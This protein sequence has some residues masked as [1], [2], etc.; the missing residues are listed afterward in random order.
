M[1][2][3][4]RIYMDL[5]GNTIDTFLFF[6]FA[7]NTLSHKIKNEYKFT[8]LCV[9][10]VYSL[11]PDAPYSTFISL[12]VN[13]VFLL[14]SA[15]PDWKRSLSVLIKYTVYS[16]ISMFL[17]LFLHSLAFNDYTTLF[18]SDIYEQYKLI[19]VLFLSY[20]AYVLYTNYRQNRR[21][22]SQYYLYFSIIIGAVCLLV[23]YSTLYICRREPSS[24]MLPLLFT[25][26][27]ILIL[28]CISL[29]DRFLE[30]IAENANY[31]IQVKINRLQENYALQIEENLKNLR[32]L[33]HDI[34]NHLIIIDGYASQKR[35]DKIHEYIQKIG[36]HFNDT[37]P[38]QTP[39]TSLSAILSEKMTLARQQKIACE[40]TCSLP[41]LKIDDFTMITILGNLLDNA[42][43][44]ASK[45]TDGWIKAA[46]L[47]ESS[48]L[49]ITVDNSHAEEIQE[50]DGT[51]I[52][53]K[54]GRSEAHGIGIKNVRRAVNNLNGQMEISYTENVFHVNIILP[55]Y[56]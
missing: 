22:R 45:C 53:T 20:V 46:L 39:S 29:Y 27:I 2:S 24:H 12:A 15:W 8:L 4:F 25:T 5:L 19:I 32:S 54:S 33:R 3:L 28:L 17:I 11:P 51:F 49:L 40:I 14:V 21:I 38:I 18:S 35:F 6:R 7:D 44:A 56:S 10:A 50:K 13:L 16:Y 55:N 48:V 34:K 1:N 37:A 47:Q 26:L 23:S 43:C 31:K 36:E 41:Y 30:L 42:I 52:T 9:Y